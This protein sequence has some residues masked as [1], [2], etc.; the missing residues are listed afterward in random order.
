MNKIAV[1]TGAN[2]G[3]GLEFCRQ[4]IAKNYQVLAVCRE[5][6]PELK[7]MTVTII[8]GVDVRELS[9]A[10]KVE[11]QLNKNKIDL[12]IHNAGIFLND[13]LGSIAKESI[14][15]QFEVNALA[16][17]LWSDRLL[18]SM[19]KDSK[20]VVI[21]S[22][23]GSIGDNSSGGYYGY[24]M[25]KA[26]LNAAAK[27]L[28]IDIAPKGIA[29]GILHPGYVKTGMTKNQGERSAENSAQFLIQR[30]EKLNLQNSGSFW[31]CEGE[32]LPW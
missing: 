18:P 24:R 28:A 10:S 4:L 15:Q 8:D 16:P 5:S 1:I 22:R 12:I 13:D 25:S 19:S 9:G 21:T 31:H 27:S 26:A 23:M 29:V 3:I 17:L 20:L 6:S 11:A 7:K 30:I 32:E 2:R 14:L